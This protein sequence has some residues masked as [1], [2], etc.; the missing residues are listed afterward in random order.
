MKELHLICNAHLDPVWQWDWDEGAA[1]ALATFFS[2]VE[3]AGEYDYIFC[4][5]EALLYEFIEKYEPEL[6]DKIRELVKAGKWHIMGGW[7][8]QPDCTVPSGEGFV[9]QIETGLKYFKEKFDVR[10]TVALNFDSFGHTQGLV[11][12]LNKCGYDGYIFCRPMV[13]DMTLP[14]RIFKW[15]GLDG[16]EIK[17]AR[18]ED[19]RI[20]SSG[21]GEAVEDIKRKMIPMQE[22]DVAFA[23]WGIGNHG[24]GP[25]RK[26]LTDIKAFA[27]EKAEE[28]VLIIH[29]TPERFFSRIDPKAELD[30]ALEP[31]FVKCYSSDSRVKVKYAEL[32]N[33]LI[34][35][36]KI[37][38]VAAAELGFVCDR[39]KIAEAQKIMSAIQFHDVLSGTSILDGERS[40]VRKADYA[41]ELL[42][43][44]FSSAFTALCAGFRRGG[45]GVYPITVYNPHPY[46]KDDIFECEIL[47]LNSLV[48]DTE[49][50]EFKI[51]K[52]GK[53]CPY[54]IIKERSTINM[55]R[56]KRFA[57]KAKLD[58][59]AVTRFDI[60]VSKGEKKQPDRTPQ[61]VFEIGEGTVA[62]FNAES[63]CLESFEAYG[64]EYLCGSAFAPVIYDDNAD[65]W[66]WWL[67]TVGKNYRYAKPEVS[68][69]VIERGEI[70]T[71]LESI[72]T[73]GKSEVRVAYR[74]YADRDYVDV[75]VNITWNDP[76]CGLKLEIPVKNSDRFIGQTSFGTQEYESELEQCSH[77]FCGV[78]S[79][80]DI[81]AV[82]KDGTYGCSVEGGKM[83]INLLNGSVYCA[84]PVGNLPIID[85]E[86]FNHYIETGRHEFSFRLT[87]C[88]EEELERLASEFVQ[89][90]YALNCYPHGDGRVAKGGTVE[91]SDANVTVSAFRE[92]ADGEYMIRLFNNYREERA[93]SCR[94]FDKSLELRFGRY[95]AKTLI[96][97]DGELFENDSMLS[98]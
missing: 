71:E 88:A 31:C 6:F 18:S 14:D 48:S 89:K 8:V 39:E 80:G 91:I 64:K 33:K 17:T 23:L 5:N 57:V 55:D 77:K 50:Y 37:C 78:E 73:T 12:I 16:S 43:E 59:M 54:Q 65:P 3:L 49:A 87:A 63:G 29:S 36:E 86:R 93:C 70:L 20:Y 68:L 62:K 2:A 56:R 32:E 52:D 44:Q 26:D 1:S 30:H 67:K 72:Y 85:E 28:G 66:G 9:R 82:F 24:G 84:H 11:Q 25:S 27:A 47:V 40:S 45:Q 96:Y 41:L 79:E 61:T 60:I 92:I 21:L 10:P 98:L 46:A 95:E 97:R 42:D 53:E 69:R 90:P 35:T 76:G 19:M 74:L 22:H 4:H 58:P 7:Y 38:A 34:V 83:Y 51:L 13:G 75:K 81:L 15:K 94:V